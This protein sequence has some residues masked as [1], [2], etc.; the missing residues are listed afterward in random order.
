M[1]E[2][3]WNG[4]IHL[5]WLYSWVSLLL[6]HVQVLLHLQRT[7]YVPLRR[8]GFAKPIAVMG[9]FLLSGFLHEYNFWTYNF[10]V[11]QPGIP[12]VF[13]LAM[14]GMMTMENLV[15]SAL[16]PACVRN[17][18]QKRIPSIFVSFVLMMILAIPVERYF[19]RSWL[20]AEMLDT[21]ALL[22]PHVTCALR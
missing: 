6:E 3:A 13:F 21:V 18:V 12:I 16:M 7:S 15:W 11:Y 19:I 17:F 2:D 22:F 1:L 8:L 9:T 4:W 10:L 20:R 5:W 14:G